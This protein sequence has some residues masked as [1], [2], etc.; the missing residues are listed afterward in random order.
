MA[1]RKFVISLAWQLLLDDVGLEAPDLLRHARLPPG[2]LSQEAPALTTEEYF[3]LWTSIETMLA[4]DDL[5]LQLGRAI[6]VESFS[7]PIF[8]AFCSP[9]LAVALKRLAKYKPLI[10]PMTLDVAEGPRGEATVTLGGLE[11]S[12]P[13]PASLILTELVFLVNMARLATRHRVEPLA[14]R[15]TATVTRPDPYT[16]FFGTGLEDAGVNGLTFS[17]TDL[18]R[19]FLSANPGMWQVFEPALR[20]RLADLTADDGFRERVRACLVESIAGGR[21]SMNDVADRLAISPRTL[22]RRLRDE[23]TSF[24]AELATLRKELARHYLKSSTYSSAEISFLLGYDDPNSFIRAFHAW[25]GETP[26]RA[27]AA[28]HM[29]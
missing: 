18:Q 14:V 16:A 28:L 8:A 13:P 19:P 21:T 2:L 22:Q 3:R 20:K 15:T 10:G 11:A 26:E 23:D 17:A 6:S 5:P 4:A 9:D 12:E 24:Q 7:P 29:H 1:A 25:T 27:R